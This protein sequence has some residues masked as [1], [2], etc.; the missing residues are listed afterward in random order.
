MENNFEFLGK[1]KADKSTF[2]ETQRLIVSEKL[3]IIITAD[4]NNF[5][6]DEQ[7]EKIL[8]LFACAPEMLKMLEIL[9]ED[10]NLDYDT[11]FEIKRLI[12]KATE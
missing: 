10:N 7:C 4:V 11:L 8:Q 9:S 5:E 12:K 3:G 2:N 6:T 1:L